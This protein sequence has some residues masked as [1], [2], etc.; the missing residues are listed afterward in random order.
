M[1]AADPGDGHAVAT[2]DPGD[3]LTA[4]PDTHVP[5][6]AAPPP[7]PLTNGLARMPALYLVPK[8]GCRSWLS[9]TLARCD[10]AH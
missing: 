7:M 8:G 10:V 3:T 4:S 6:V 9:V 1:A 2:A 5:P